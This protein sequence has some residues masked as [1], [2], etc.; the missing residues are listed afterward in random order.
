VSRVRKTTESKQRWAGRAQ[1]VEPG[2]DF[3]PVRTAHDNNGAP[4]PRCLPLAFNGQIQIEAVQPL[5]PPGWAPLAVDGS[6]PCCF[7]CQAA[8]TVLKML[9]RNP[10]KARPHLTKLVSKR[11][12]TR[13]VAS[14][15]MDFPMARV[16]V[17]NDRCEQHRLPG[18]PM[19]LV[20]EGWVRASKPG[21]FE[22]HL[23]WMERMHLG[24]GED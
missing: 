3:D 11:V 7:D 20:L 12:L 15:G 17:A 13:E 2:P 14:A 9:A 16:C 4:C 5:P 23:A 6:G 18:V 10:G 21:D 24:E 8:D 22:R 1:A 19:G